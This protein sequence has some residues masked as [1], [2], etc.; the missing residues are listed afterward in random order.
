M[1]QAGRGKAAIADEPNLVLRKLVLHKCDEDLTWSRG[2]LGSG[3]EEKR[4]NK[5]NAQLIPRLPWN[6]L[7]GYSPIKILLANSVFTLGNT[8]N[9][10]SKRA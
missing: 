5:G 8:T 1:A 3:R 6:F 10:S 7:N 2:E 4:N 9:S